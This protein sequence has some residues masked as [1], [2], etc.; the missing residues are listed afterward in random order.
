MIA[1]LQQLSREEFPEAEVT[2][3][4]VLLSHL[5]ESVLRD[6]W[7]TFAVAVAGIGLLMT[8][9]FRDLRLALIA[10]LPNAFP[11]LVVLGTMGWVSALFWPDLKINMGTAMIAA[12]SMGLSIDSSI[13]YILGFQQL[14]ATGEGV[15]RGLAAG[16]ATRWQGDGVVDVRAGDRLYRARHQPLRADDLLRRPRDVGHAGWAG[17]QSD[18]TAVADQAVLPSPP[19]VGPR[20]RTFGDRRAVV[21][22]RGACGRRSL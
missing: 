18:W 22:P 14:V 19:S 13:H 11:V 3:Y 2:G 21:S 8:I 16:S 9:A 7:N 12:V 5:I 10:L 17:R 1:R 20:I 15:E 4:F 6:Q